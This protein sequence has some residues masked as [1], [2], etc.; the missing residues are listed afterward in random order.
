MLPN[1]DPTLQTLLRQAGRRPPPPGW[2]TAEVYQRTRRAWEAQLRRRQ[3]MRRG[4]ALAAGLVLALLVGRITWN[5]YPHQVVAAAP[6]GQPVL[7]THTAWHPFASRLGGALYAGDSV[8]TGAASA[9]L[10]GPG[11]TELRIARDTQL[12]LLSADRL[13]LKHGRLFVQTGTLASIQHLA[14]ITGLG[15]VEHLGTRFIVDRERD[16]LVVAVRDGRVAL[17]YGFDQAVELQAGQ[18]AHVDTQG[19][20]RRWALAAFDE[21]WDWADAMA[22]PLVVDGQT[23]YAVLS[24]IAQRAGLAL[25]FEGAEAEAEAQRLSLHGAPLQLQPRFALDAVL[26]TTTLAGSTNGREIVISTR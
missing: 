15:T 25:R 26:A 19:G 14:V 8:Q 23:L 10:H 4:Y 18:A 9:L 1:D 20:M 6:E 12:L 24:E 22:S 13:D 2:V 16:A 17:H 7:I 5:F 3:L 11:G 21:T